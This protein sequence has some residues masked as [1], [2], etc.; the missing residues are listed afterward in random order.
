MCLWSRRQM[1]L[2]ELELV[3]RFQRIVAADGDQGVDA[4]RHQRVVDRLQGGGALGVLQMGRLRDVFAGVGPRGAEDDA[5]AVARPLQHAVRDADIVAALDHGMVGSVFDE[6]RIAVPDA[7]D[8]DVVAQE[9][10]GRR[11]DHGVGRRGRA[12]GKQDRHAANVRIEMRGRR[13]RIA[14]GNA[15]Q[16]I[17]GESVRGRWLVTGD[18]LPRHR[19]EMLRRPGLFG[20]V[21]RLLL[22][23]FRWPPACSPGA[24]RLPRRGPGRKYSLPRAPSS[25]S[26]RT[27]ARTVVDG[28]EGQRL[29][30]GQ[31]RRE[32]PAARGSAAA[33]R[34]RPSPPAGRG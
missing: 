15:P 33:G 22:H 16:E 30:R 13:Q 34:T 20:H 31:A 25:S 23:T 18:R 29:L 5:L 6:V 7:V 32:R 8:F 28:A 9:G 21:R 19:P 24:R 10:H 4:Q 17:R 14:H 27:S 2:V 26:R 3:G 11:G 12:A 1:L